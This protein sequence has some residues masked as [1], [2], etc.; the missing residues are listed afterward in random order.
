MVTAV[1]E[2]IGVIR[3]I[4]CVVQRQIRVGLVAVFADFMKLRA[5]LICPD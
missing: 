4:V 1:V 5:Q 2:T 3:S